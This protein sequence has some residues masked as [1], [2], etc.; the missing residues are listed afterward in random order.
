MKKSQ[1]NK[2]LFIK[3]KDFV[4]L[5]VEIYILNPNKIY[6]LNVIMDDWLMMIKGRGMMGSHKWRKYFRG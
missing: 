1:I 4:C 2:K 5:S 3:Q 6:L